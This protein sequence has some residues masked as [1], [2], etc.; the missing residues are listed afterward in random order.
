M[1][2]KILSDSNIYIA[3]RYFAF[4]V[5]AIASA[6]FNIFLFTALDPGWTY[7]LVSLSLALEG[8]KLTTVIS[9]SVVRS[10]YNKL[11]HKPLLKKSKNL[12]KWYLVYGFLSIMA[13]LGFS[14]YITARTQTIR[15]SGL[16]I[17][18]SRKQSIE[19]K[20]DEILNLRQSSSIGTYLE[21]QPWIT[22]NEIWM[23]EDAL[24][25]TAESR[26]AILRLER[27][28]ILDRDSEDW[29]RANQVFQAQSNYLTQV[30]STRNRA[31][32]ERT[33]IQ[34]TFENSKHD[35]EGAL[36]SLNDELQ[37]I[38]K[39]A[40]LDA[41]NGS[42]AL[43]ILQERIQNEEIKMI[44]DKGLT[45]MFEG[46]SGYTGGRIPPDMIK[47]FILLLASVLLELTI[48]QCAPSIKIS[49]LILKY[50]KRDLP[51]DKTFQ[52]IIDLYED[53][54]NVNMKKSIVE[55]KEIIKEPIQKQEIIPV[56]EP[57]IIEK[58]KK[59]RKPRDKKIIREVPIEE[60]SKI[61]DENIK[62]Q[63]NIIDNLS[64][65]IT[66]ALQIS[67]E[68]KLE[69]KEDDQFV[70]SMTLKE[71]ESFSKIENQEIK[72]EIAISE[73][74][75]QQEI[76]EPQTEIPEQ[77]EKVEEKLIHYKFGKTTENI[78]AKLINFI[79][80]CVKEEGAFNMP[81]DYAATQLKLGNK[82]KQV[83]LDKLLAI[84]LGSK[85]LITKNKYGEYYANYSSKQII[86]YISGIVN[87]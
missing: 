60:Q 84:R 78:M 26:F 66:Q 52:E 1:K 46:F 80:L 17:L 50:F 6:M 47:I 70:R 86:D 83:F 75:Q 58:V 39:Q 15:N 20:M 28:N 77:Q 9:I 59:P 54:E 49:P 4:F 64:D 10:L 68:E 13:S 32:A 79:E 22:A 62:K 24:V 12:F 31:D 73:T 8:A 48:F 43:I 71:K 2:T 67:N 3:V 51:E 38:F 57:V 85:S 5:A 16:E 25:R 19:A 87:D 65:N 37:I 45:Y 74:N 35:M 42:I 41:P 76:I 11:N 29:L 55:E 82:A 63:E 40:D 30:R 7:L 56:I 69:P 44:H 36:A 18:I 53:E 23:E 27:D 61:L 14:T 34:A 33:R 81:P 72:E 21:F